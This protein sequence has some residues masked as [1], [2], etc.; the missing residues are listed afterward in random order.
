MHEMYISFLSALVCVQGTDCAVLLSRLCCVVGTKRAPTGPLVLLQ[1]PLI[2]SCLCCGAPWYSYSVYSSCPAS[3][4]GPR[5]TVTASTLHV[6]P[7][8]RGPVECNSNECI[9]FMASHCFRF[10]FFGEGLICCWYF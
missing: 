6:L 3:F 9:V 7:L 8:L 1:R 5:G 10:A 2:M 4:V